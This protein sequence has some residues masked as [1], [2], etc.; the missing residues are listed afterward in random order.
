MADSASDRPASSIRPAS[1]NRVP[2][3]PSALFDSHAGQLREAASLG[4]IVDLACGRGRHTLACARLGLPTIGIDRDPRLLAQLHSAAAAGGLPL[5]CVR[6]DLESGHG[7]P[8]V[9]GSC[10]AILVFRFL[11]RPL[12]DA[13][14]EA[15]CPGGLLLYETFTSPQRE[16][17]GGPR[18]DRYLLETGELA[19]LFPSLE[20]LS[21]HEGIAERATASL[22][23]RKP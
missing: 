3:P 16:L 23:A 5:S 13:I 12:A 11:F 1:G 6:T 9:P 8:L 4:P 18:S 15:L 10:G 2:S 19:Q 17:E 7:I 20:T 21:L 22:V 14:I